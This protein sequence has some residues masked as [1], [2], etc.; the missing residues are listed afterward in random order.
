MT[1]ASNNRP[2]PVQ[3]K[4]KWVTPMMSLMDARCSDGKG[5]YGE[6]GVSEDGVV[7]GSS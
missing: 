5:P 1:S 3:E 4:L 7:F 6:E 2:V